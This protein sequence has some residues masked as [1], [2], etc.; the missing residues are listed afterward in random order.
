MGFNVSVMP[1]GKVAGYHAEN[2]TANPY[3]CIGCLTSGVIKSAWILA[4][5]KLCVHAVQLI[6]SQVQNRLQ[7]PPAEWRGI[8]WYVEVASADVQKQHCILCLVLTVDCGSEGTS[9][10]LFCSVS[11]MKDKDWQCSY[12]WGLLRNHILNKRFVKVCW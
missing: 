12:L 3:V 7:I 5:L 8:D 4:C 2:M 11:Y 1:E 10:C 9:F 6:G